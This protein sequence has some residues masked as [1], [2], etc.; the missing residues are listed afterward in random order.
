MF[1]RYTKMW[2]STYLHINTLFVVIFYLM[3]PSGPTQIAF[4]RYRYICIQIALIEFNKCGFANCNPSN[5]PLQS[6]KRH[7]PDNIS[8]HAVMKLIIHLKSIDVKSQ[9]FVGEPGRISEKRRIVFRPTLLYSRHATKMY[10]ALCE[11]INY[12]VLG[13][14]QLPS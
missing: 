10:L 4:Q 14:V 5:G 11:G 1:I 8:F 12:R 13:I 7:T 9:L 3:C 2:I 6:F